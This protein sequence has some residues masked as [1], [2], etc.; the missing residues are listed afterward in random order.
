MQPFLSASTALNTL[1]LAHRACAPH[2]R[3]GI[4]IFIVSYC[5]DSA[6]G[7]MK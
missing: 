4:T 5:V 6:R 3:G 1:T 2:H 7:R